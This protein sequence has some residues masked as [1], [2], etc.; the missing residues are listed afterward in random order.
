[1]SADLISGKEIAA[2]LREDVAASVAEIKAKHGFTPGLAV[3]LV[4]EDPASQ[5]YVRN[6]G[7][8]TEEAGMN[9]YTHRLPENATQ[10]EVEALLEKL[11]SDEAVDGILLQLPLPKHLAEPGVKDMVRISDG[12]M[13]GTAYGTVVL[14]VAP[15]AAVGGVLALVR[16][17]DMIELDVEAGR[18]DLLVEEE[19]LARRRAELVL[20]VLPKRGWRRLY[21]ERVMQANYG[22]DLDFMR[23]DS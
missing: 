12:R 18:V 7:V 8:M 6:K 23:D 13:S 14:H 16:D 22:A 3:V 1:M 20:P 9:S 10:G 19:E 17:G 5:I 4:G 2:R 15:E 11:N 21:G